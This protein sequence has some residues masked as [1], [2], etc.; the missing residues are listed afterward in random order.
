MQKYTPFVT[1]FIQYE[2]CIV[3]FGI[4]FADGLS[5]RV[6]INLL[7]DC[8]GYVTSFVDDLRVYSDSLEEHL[9]HIRLVLEKLR[10]AGL[11]LNRKKCKFVYQEVKFLGTIVGNSYVR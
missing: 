11:T 7:N 8:Q 10:K 5:N 2:F 4:K 3:P 1:E 6:I 9:V